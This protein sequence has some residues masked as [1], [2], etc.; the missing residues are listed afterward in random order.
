MSRLTF[1]LLFA[2]VFCFG[3]GSTPRQDSTHTTYVY[4]DW[5]QAATL[6]L[7]VSHRDNVT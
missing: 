6:G 4:S 3:C 5:Q 2:I 1:V 7:W